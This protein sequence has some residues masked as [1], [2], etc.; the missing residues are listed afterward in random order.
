MLNAPENLTRGPLGA[1]LAGCVLFWL[2]SAN[3]ENLVF[4]SGPSDI[5][6]ATRLLTQIGSPP[7]SSDR[8]SIARIDLN[9]D[10][11]KEVITHQSG[12][13]WTGTHGQPYNI[14]T[15]DKNSNWNCVLMVLANSIGVSP[16]TSNGWKDLI[17]NGKVRWAWKAGSYDLK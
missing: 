9:N 2:S 1:L 16:Q 4:Q 7:D 6:L 14:F 3:A 15:K 8:I 13:G 17:L 5:A 12:P 11:E 10:G